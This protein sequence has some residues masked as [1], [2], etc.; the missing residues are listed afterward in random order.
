MK[1]TAT[2]ASQT[3]ASFIDQDDPEEPLFVRSMRRVARET[4][5][6]WATYRLPNVT[7]L[8]SFA[9]YAAA[10]NKRREIAI[11]RS[12]NEKELSATV[13][14]ITRGFVAREED[15]TERHAQAILDGRAN[16]AFEGFEE[17]KSQQARLTRQL[18]AYVVAI[19]TQ[20]EAIAAI[21]SE[22]SIDAAE[23]MVPA[24]RDAVTAIASA[25]RQLREAFDREEA[26][27]TLVTNAGYDSRL[28]SFGSGAIMQGGHLED[29][30]RRAHEYIR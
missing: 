5:A 10:A 4:V 16:E 22:R 23:T 29:I 11:E 1:I 28:P 8:A 26:T 17:L 24:H 25:I 3:A 20:D 2:A 30:E 18:K 27:R 15:E 6:R 21:R 7:P 13:T 9:D 14:A 19:R 12:A